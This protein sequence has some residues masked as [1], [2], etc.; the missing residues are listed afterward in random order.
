MS[1]SKKQQILN[2]LQA[3]RGVTGH[4]A[5]Y[6]FGVYRLSSTIHRLRQEG[7]TIH[8]EMIEEDGQTYAKYIYLSPPKTPRFPSLPPSP[9]SSNSD[10]LIGTL[11]I[12]I[13]P[14]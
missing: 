13:R 14:E 4:T 7:H 11:D 5:L 6:H 8:T 3:G 10:G 2:F 1:Y 12:T 9:P